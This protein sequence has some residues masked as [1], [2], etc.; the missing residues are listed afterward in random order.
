MKRYCVYV[1]TDNGNYIEM[2]NTFEEAENYRI[3]AE[4][5]CGY[6]AELLEQDENGIYWEI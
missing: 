3:K 4:W 5:G 1:R 6:Y 2:F